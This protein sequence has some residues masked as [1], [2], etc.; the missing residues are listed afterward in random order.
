[1][2][3]AELH[4]DGIAPISGEANIRGAVNIK[5]VPS[6]DPSSDLPLDPPADLN[7]DHDGAGTL[8]LLQGGENK[9]RDGDGVTVEEGRPDGEVVVALVGVGDGGG[10]GDLLAAV[11][12]VEA[13]R[14]VVDADAR[15]G[16]VGGEGDLHGE[17]EGVGDGG[18][19]VE[20]EEG[21]VLEREAGLGGAEDDPYEEDNEEDQENESAG[22]DEDEPEETAAGR[23]VVAAVLGGHGGCWRIT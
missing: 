22:A 15:V 5:V 8:V 4:S 20:V 7:V 9:R 16:V 6:R 19:E 14:V 11:G 13:E 21:G 17:G 2:Q 10:E 1:M 3:E 18:G 23:V 12:G